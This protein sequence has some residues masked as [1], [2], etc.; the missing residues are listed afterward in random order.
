[1]IGLEYY[2]MVTTAYPQEP[3][4]HYFFAAFLVTPSGRFSNSALQHFELAV[5]CS[6]SSPRFIDGLATFLFQLSD[7]VDEAILERTSKLY[8]VALTTQS[9]NSETRSV[10]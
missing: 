7:S 3:L 1:M 8:E 10:R 5:K 6:P 2:K 9:N 4:Y